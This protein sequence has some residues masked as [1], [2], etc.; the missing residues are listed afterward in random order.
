MGIRHEL[1]YVMNQGDCFATLAITEDVTGEIDALA[2][3][4]DVLREL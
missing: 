4:E 2:M 1:R 3:T